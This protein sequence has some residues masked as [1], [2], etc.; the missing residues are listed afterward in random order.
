MKAAQIFEAAVNFI[1]LVQT[2]ECIFN[3]CGN[4]VGK[5]GGGERNGIPYS[6]KIHFNAFPSLHNKYFHNKEHNNENIEGEKNKNAFRPFYQ[7]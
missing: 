3:G 2:E 7:L 6:K 1:F 5:G 4:R